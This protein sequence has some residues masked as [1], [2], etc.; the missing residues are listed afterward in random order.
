MSERV[1]LIA[2]LVL[3]L[4]AP[5][6]HA[7]QAPPAP[8]A[9][10]AAEARQARAEARFVLA[11]D[12]LLAERGGL[13]RSSPSR[14]L[15]IGGLV[16][17]VPASVTVQEGAAAA[18]Q[19][20]SMV[21]G[22]Y[23]PVLPPDRRLSVWWDTTAG[24]DRRALTV[25][26][27][28]DTIPVEA[29]T[30]DASSRVVIGVMEGLRYRLTRTLDS[31]LTEWVGAFPMEVGAP[32]AA[33]LRMVRRALALSPSTVAHE[34]LRGTVASCGAIFDLEGPVA[35]LDRWYRPADLPVIAK[36]SEGLRVHSTAWQRCAWAD[37][38]SVCHDLVNVLPGTVIPAPM[39]RFTRTILMRFALAT[40]GAG[41]IPRVIAARGRTVV[42][43]LGAA[44]G[45]S[46]PQLLALWTRTVSG[47]DQQRD[48]TAFVFASGW[49]CVLLGIAAG[50]LSRRPA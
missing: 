50:L 14:E 33:E 41:A 6:V 1:R 42:D 37:D 10:R 11:H 45:D 12:S 2:S 39:P 19:L 13:L 31:P 48:P 40:G 34:C 35:P 7:T 44:A 4:L 27:A 8:V 23:A 3:G 20:D 17:R 49:A 9:L 26:T 46:G 24:E 18:A 16:V 25:M 30:A 47:G 5:P 29:G 15:T 38:P 36:S 43:Q 22:F 32:D 21:A 28:T